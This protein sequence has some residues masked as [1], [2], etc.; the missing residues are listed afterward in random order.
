MA[1]LDGPFRFLPHQDVDHMAR[2]EAL[3]GA[4]NARKGLLGRNRGVP[5]LGGIL[6]VVTAS[7]ISR[8]FLAE[9]GQQGLSAATHGLTKSQHGVELLAAQALEGFRPLAALDH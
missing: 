8:M 9:I 6:A 7:A 4:E 1:E 2:A 5:G 3:A